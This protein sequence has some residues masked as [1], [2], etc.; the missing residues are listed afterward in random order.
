M[1][2]LSPEHAVMLNK[3]LE[4]DFVPHLPPL[5]N[6][7][8]PQDEQ[9]KKNLSRAFSAFALHHLCGASKVDAAKAVVDDFDDYGLDAVFYDAPSETLYLVQSKL[10]ASEQFSQDEALAFCQGARKLIKQDFSGFNANVQARMTDIED[11]IG[12]CSHIALVV[13]H[14]GSGISA[15]AKK[16][17]DDLIADE[18]PGDERLDQPVI[19]YD[20]VRVVADLRGDKAYGPVDA[21]LFVQKC[22]NVN[23]PRV[24][25]FG[26][27]Q[28]EDLVKLHEKHGKA[29]Y[30]KNIRTFLGHKTDVN[31]AIQETLKVKPQEFMYLNNGV[32]ALC[33]RIEP[34]GAAHAKGGKKRLKLTGFSVING[35]QTIASSAK[36][37]VDNKETDIS[38]ARV[39]LTLIKADADG[40]F[41]K[42][43]TRARN[44]QN[45]VVY[46]NF[47][48]LDDEQERLRRDLAYL[49]IHYSYKA[50]AAEANGDPSYIKI[51]E[52]AHALA[53]FQGDPRFPI[54][55]KKEPGQLLNTSSDQY[56]AL[57]PANRTA[58]ELANAVFFFRYTQNQMRI[59]ENAAKYTERLAYKHGVYIV[60]WVL[61]KRVLGEAK[62]TA[63]F[64][65][66]KVKTS[67][68]VPFDSLR[69]LH[70]D[71]TKATG[72]GPLSL[73]R[74]Q[75]YALPLI[76]EIAIAD[77]GLA[78]DPAVTHKKT[79]EQYAQP[80]PKELFA[81][82]VSK[83]PQVGG[84]A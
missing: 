19:S 20:S 24:T 18:D 37:V 42:S 9:N 53:L 34:K 23:D 77:Y 4:T 56:K 27:V 36:F 62:K 70:W 2:A 31:R 81:Y 1:S 82:I 12:S 69:Q 50:E 11:A 59:Q 78:G 35:A 66:D 13:A 60:A 72:R 83:A 17:L 68:S 7:T 73:F 14:T 10:K 25:Y 63:L 38:S 29:L 76:Q 58:F 16:A 48:A 64:S 8:K 57:F 15:R 43:V 6:K 74:T 51:D 40:E 33:Q 28:L 65:Q 67:L 49:G 52:A 5:L 55:L 61:A 39:A 32:T 47:A 41:G 71:R 26:L 45:P 46:S 44:H 84:L 79:Q 22:Q 75:G 80:Y 3:A 54:W 30:E 21:D